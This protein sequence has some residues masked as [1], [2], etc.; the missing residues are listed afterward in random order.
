MIE[1]IFAGIEDG[2]IGTTFF[3]TFTVLE[4][5]LGKLTILIKCLTMDQYQF[6]SSKTIWNLKFNLSSKVLTEIYNSITLWCGK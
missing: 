1:T 6:L 3:M 2:L 4:I 5:L